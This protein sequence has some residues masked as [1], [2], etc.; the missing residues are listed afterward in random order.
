M[1]CQLWNE[2][3]NYRKM[4]AMM[5]YIYAKIMIRLNVNLMEMSMRSSKSIIIIFVLPATKKCY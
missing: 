2:F 1:V 5:R 4:V 3:R